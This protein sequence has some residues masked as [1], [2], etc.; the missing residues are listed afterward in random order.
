MQNRNE[1]NIQ[2]CIRMRFAAKRASVLARNIER[3]DDC[4]AFENTG[5]LQGEGQYL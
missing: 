1:S 3:F 2:V 4:T 5:V